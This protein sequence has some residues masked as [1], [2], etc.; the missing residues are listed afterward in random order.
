MWA[1]NNV[2]QNKLAENS[3]LLRCN[4]FPYLKRRLSIFNGFQWF[5][6]INPNNNNNNNNKKRRDIGVT[7]TKT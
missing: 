7:N 3:T 6:A 2:L 4:L 1:K 5:D